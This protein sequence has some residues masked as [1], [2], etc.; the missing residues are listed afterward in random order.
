[1]LSAII[2]LFVRV[3]LLIA[4]EPYMV[5]IYREVTLLLIA[6][7]LTTPSFLPLALIIPWQCTTVA[8][9]FSFLCVILKNWEWP[10][11]LTRCQ[12]NVQCRNTTNYAVVCLLH[13]YMC[14]CV[15]FP[16]EKYKLVINN[17][18]PLK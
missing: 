5:G 15:Q 1:M 7:N 11:L 13:L 16:T 4:L 14:V 9:I 8:S 17:I 12:F 3:K 6:P 18:R 2:V 10:G